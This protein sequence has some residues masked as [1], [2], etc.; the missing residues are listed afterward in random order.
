M[1]G[2]PISLEDHPDRKWELSCVEQK[3]RWDGLLYITHNSFLPNTL[4]K[5]HPVANITTNKPQTYL[6]FE[7]KLGQNHSPNR[8]VAI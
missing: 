7:L 6:S 2:C 8:F 4:F 5:G 1:T 3:K